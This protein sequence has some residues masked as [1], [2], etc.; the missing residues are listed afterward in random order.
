VFGILHGIGGN[1]PW[2]LALLFPALMIGRRFLM[3]GRGGNRR[4]G[5][6]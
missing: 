1:R 2:Y 6:W 4:R 5:R 3:R